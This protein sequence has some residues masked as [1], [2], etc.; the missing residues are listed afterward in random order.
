MRNKPA[1]RPHGKAF[2]KNLFLLRS[3]A[4]VRNGGEMARVAKYCC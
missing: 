4:S 1:R 2:V 3:N